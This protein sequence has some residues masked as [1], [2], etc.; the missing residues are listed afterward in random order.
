MTDETERRATRMSSMRDRW[1]EMTTA[2]ST[3]RLRRANRP[4]QRASGS[5]SS[6]LS[7][8]F[9]D[10]KA[11]RVAPP[12]RRSAAALTIGETQGASGSSGHARR[13]EAEPRW[14]SSGPD[15]EHREPHEPTG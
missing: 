4:S 6:E 5:G 13:P 7:P 9:A 1:L 2:R 3:R 8:A 15:L 11:R 12:A 14:Y 10:V